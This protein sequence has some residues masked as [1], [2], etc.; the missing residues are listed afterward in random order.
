MKQRFSSLDVKVISHELSKSLV[1]LRI[2][3]IYDLSSR[4]FLFKCAKPGARQQ[5]LVDSGFRCHLTAFTRAAAATPSAF[6]ARL[7]KYLKSRRI[8][9]VTQIG[10]DRVIEI[11]FSDGQ[12][13]L[14]LE[15][16]AA[17]NLVLTD[18]D[19]TILALLRQVSEGDVDVD[20]KLDSQYPVKAKQNSEGRPPLT[21]ESV[22]LVIA[23]HVKRVAA[24][25]ELGGKKAKRHKGGDDLGKALSSGFPEIT[26]HLL[27]HVFKLMGFDATIK[28]SDVLE[29]EEKLSQ[30]MKALDRAETIFNELGN[31]EYA[32]GYIVSKR[33]TQPPEIAEEGEVPPPRSQLLYEDF[34]PFHPSQF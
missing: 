5:L 8:T 25:T 28:S 27:D 24:A 15:F 33:K 18:K 20:V 19:F 14:F 4:I 9:S 10:T 1:S 29:N 26:I 2:A 16:F 34:H 31:P 17:G 7:R 23:E 3:N 12:Y 22:R 11:A 32:K 6:V 30:L 13:R 21:E